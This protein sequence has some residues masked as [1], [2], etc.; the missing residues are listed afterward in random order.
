MF[1]AMIFRKEPFFYGHDN[2][3]QLVQIVRVR[4]TK[5]LS[6]CIYIH[7]FAFTCHLHTRGKADH[8][9]HI[10]S[11]LTTKA[12]ST[13]VYI[14]TYLGLARTI[15][16]HVIKWVFLGRYTVVNGVYI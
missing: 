2:A 11:V 14:C 4:R 15:Y 13:R 1:A 9:V 12:L 7:T 10:V 8:L 16:T 5:G 3:D 6:A